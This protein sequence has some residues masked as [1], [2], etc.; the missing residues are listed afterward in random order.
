MTID[1]APKG[2]T[3]L[4]NNISSKFTNSHKNPQLTRNFRSSLNPVYEEDE[5]SHEQDNVSNARAGPSNQSTQQQFPPTAPRQSE[6]STT[7]PPRPAL[8][9]PM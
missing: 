4:K 8:L 1:K 7:W 6:T 3:W 5:T 9:I 2:L